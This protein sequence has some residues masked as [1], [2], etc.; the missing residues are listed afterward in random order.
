MINTNGFFITLEGIEG[1]G[2]ST[3]LKFIQK[4]LQQKNIEPVITR[5]PGGTPVAE[6][7]RNILL[8]PNTE[9]ITPQTELLILFAG[10][11][12]HIANV[13]KPALTAGKWILCDR[14]TD[15]S[16][17]YQGYGRGMPLQEIE[18]LEQWVQEDL[19]P[20]LTFLFDAPVAI[21]QRR[22]KGRGNLDRIEQERADFFERVRTGYL[23]RAAEFPQ[24]Y[25]VIDASVPLFKVQQQIQIILDTL[26]NDH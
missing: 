23:A 18:Y 10:R 7:L 8:V 21:A 22:V 26:L 9:N 5:E 1:V 17:A 19:R 24:R 25:R 12:Q 6:A 20:D 13:I 3:H 4:Y 2:K 14:F 11:S 15:A 16:F